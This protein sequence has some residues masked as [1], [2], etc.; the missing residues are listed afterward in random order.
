MNNVNN[1]G[2]DTTNSKR[3]TMYTLENRT[4]TE[5]QEQ[6]VRKV[7]ETIGDLENVL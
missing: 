2:L 1:L 6:Y 7:V 3:L 4:V 5:V